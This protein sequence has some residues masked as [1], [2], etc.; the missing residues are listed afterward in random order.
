MKNTGIWIDTKEAKIV[1]LDGLQIK[2]KTVFSE[3]DR[4]PRVKGETSQKKVRGFSGFDYKSVQESHFR[5]ELKKYFRSVINEVKG[6]DNIFLFGPA[7]AR[8]MLEKEI[9]QDNDIQS[10][11][12]KVEACDALTENQL[13]D[14]VK[15]FF[16]ERSGINPKLR[17]L[18]H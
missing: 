12:L 14:K 18:P 5:E 1:E 8:L 13:I 2:V 6:S 7:E 9:H 4:K 11:I 10:K 3:T 15:S 16:A 17:K